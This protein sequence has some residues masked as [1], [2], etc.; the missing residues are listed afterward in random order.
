MTSTNMNIHVNIFVYIYT[1]VFGGQSEL[2]KCLTVCVCAAYVLVITGV[3]MCV[4][5]KGVFPLCLYVWRHGL[6]LSLSFGQARWP[7]SIRY[8]PITL[9]VVLVPGLQVKAS[10]GFYIS[11][12]DSNSGLC[13]CMTGTLSTKP[14]SQPPYLMFWGSAELLSKA[15]APIYTPICNG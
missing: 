8:L 4:G 13:V 3:F 2:N 12:G 7:M 15:T 6:L 5:A 11:S 14:F 10:L 1:F 9:L